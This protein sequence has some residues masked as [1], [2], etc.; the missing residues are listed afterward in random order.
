MS[1]TGT[2][3]RVSLL[4]R[5]L[6]AGGLHELAAKISAKAHVCMKHGVVEDPIIAVVSPRHTQTFCPWCSGSAVLAAWEA[7]GR[8]S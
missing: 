8:L 5:N 7:E 1:N 3:L 4:A 6:R 2:V